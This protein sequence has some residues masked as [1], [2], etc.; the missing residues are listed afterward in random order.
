MATFSYALALLL[1]AAHHALQKSLSSDS[2]YRAAVVEMKSVE[3]IFKPVQVMK[4][5]EIKIL[6]FIDQAA[7]KNVD[8][9]VF[10]ELPLT[11]L[12][13]PSRRYLLPWTTVLPDPSQYYKPCTNFSIAVIESIRSISC[14]AKRKRIYVVI[15]VIEQEVCSTAGC[16]PDGYLLYISNVVFDREGRII[17][18]SKLLIFTVKIVRARKNH[19]IHE[20]GNI[21]VKTPQNETFTT[22]FG[23]TFGHIICYDIMFQRPWLDVRRKLNVTD[24]VFTS[25]WFTGMPF[26]NSLQVQAGFSYA[27]DVNML[28]AGYNAVRGGLTGSGIYLGRQG[29]ASALMAFDDHEELVIADVPKKSQNTVANASRQSDQGYKIRNGF[30]RRKESERLIMKY[31]TLANATMKMIVENGYTTQTLHHEGIECEFKVNL[32]NLNPPTIYRLIAFDGTRLDGK[33]VRCGNRNCAI[34]QCANETIESCGAIRNSSGI[35]TFIEVESTHI[36]N[37]NTTMIPSTVLTD[38][39]PLENWTFDQHTSGRHVHT[40]ISLETPSENVVTFGVWGRNFER[41][42][43]IGAIHVTY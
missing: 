23:V 43:R 19:L 13:F 3:D 4:A 21:N 5:N 12:A 9:L 33:T 30:R 39:F 34:H 28:A 26:K 15:N 27:E 18:R 10:P 36:D 32:T 20:N 17:S 40:K 38:L 1:L 29:I 8:I 25:G 2:T 6:N 14:A 24:F 16:P 22:D 35:F 31:E 37:N 11:S 7:E 41:D 42:E